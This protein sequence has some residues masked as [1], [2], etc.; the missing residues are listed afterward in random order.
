MECMRSSCDKRLGSAEQG[1]GTSLSRQV[2]ADHKQYAYIVC[3]D[4]RS[5]RVVSSLLV[6]TSCRPQIL[7]STLVYACVTL[8]KCVHRNL[9][10]VYL[11]TRYL[12]RQNRF[13]EAISRPSA[14]LLQ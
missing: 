9:S 7:N 4:S 2:G 8:T 11:V 13:L 14:D 5:R 1:I 10:H 6:R 12:M 3:V